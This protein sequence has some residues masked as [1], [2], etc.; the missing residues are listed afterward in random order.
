MANTYR[1]I[2]IPATITIS[3]S[4]LRSIRLAAALVDISNTATITKRQAVQV[5]VKAFRKP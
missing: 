2:I 5:V 3:T 4:P 1:R